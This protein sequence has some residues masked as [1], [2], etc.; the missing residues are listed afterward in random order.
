MGDLC[1][2]CV[3][4]PSEEVLSMFLTP[5]DD[6]KSAAK[7]S[8]ADSRRADFRGARGLGA[9]RSLADVAYV[10]WETFGGQVSLKGLTRIDHDELSI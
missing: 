1:T 8:F 9:W 6:T 2:K 4:A 7:R 10:L 5:E 3:A